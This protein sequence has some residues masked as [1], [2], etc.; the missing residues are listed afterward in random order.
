EYRRVTQ[1]VKPI[2]TNLLR[3]HMENLETKMRWRR[4]PGIGED[5]PAAGGMVRGDQILEA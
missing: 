5:D 4:N 3:P 1:S 2:A